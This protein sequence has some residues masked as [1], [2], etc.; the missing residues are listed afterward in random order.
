MPAVTPA[1]EG[2]HYIAARVFIVIP[3]AWTYGEL[4]L[5]WQGMS[6]SLLV[7]VYA[8]RTVLKRLS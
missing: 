4:N 7:A 6:E 3:C 8:P 2:D 1:P 5:S